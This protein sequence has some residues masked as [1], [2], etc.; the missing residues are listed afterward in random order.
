[1]IEKENF[2][3]S[4]RDG[5]KIMEGYNLSN[6]E[7]EELYTSVTS[8]EPLPEE[9][10]FFYQIKDGLHQYELKKMELRLI[11]DSIINVIIFNEK[12]EKTIE[13]KKDNTDFLFVPL[14]PG[15]V[16]DRFKHKRVYRGVFQHGKV[17]IQ[18]T[19]KE[20]TYLKLKEKLEYL[21]GKVMLKKVELDFD[22]PCSNDAGVYRVKVKGELEYS[23]L[24]E[25]YGGFVLVFAIWDPEALEMR[26][27][28][29]DIFSEPTLDFTPKRYYL[30]WSNGDGTYSTLDIRI[31]SDN[32]D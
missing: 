13:S 25:E 31:L 19:K 1:M 30:R 14:I 24:R 9:D 32:I 23:R 5:Y 29:I 16:P 10:P 27:V 8:K 3:W 20:I 17:A 12:D 7:Y 26:D 15:I 28:E 6:K 4:P 21:A 18:K 2:T 11:D 22:H